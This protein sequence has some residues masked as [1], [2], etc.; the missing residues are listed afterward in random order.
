MY[1]TS[2]DCDTVP[3]PSNLTDYKFPPTLSVCNETILTPLLGSKSDG[4]WHWAKLCMLM[5]GSWERPPVHFDHVGAGYLALFQTATFE[6]W[7]EVIQS[8][9]DH[10][11]DVS[12]SLIFSHCAL[13]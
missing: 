7:M 2:Y 13:S 9:V 6:G 4:Q 12:S 5:G 3:I 8:A 10:N 1:P 11:K